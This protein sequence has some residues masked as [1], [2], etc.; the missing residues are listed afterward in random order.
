MVA[1]DPAE[2][3]EDGN[4][5]RGRS[6]SL[7]DSRSGSPPPATKAAVGDAQEERTDENGMSDLN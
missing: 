3:A 6:L 4:L 5:G 7:N 2:G 1:C